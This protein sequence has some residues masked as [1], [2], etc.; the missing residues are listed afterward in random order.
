[1]YA[2]GRSPLSIGAAPTPRSGR[3]FITAKHLVMPINN[4][5]AR[6][7]KEKICFSPEYFFAAARPWARRVVPGW[8]AARGRRLVFP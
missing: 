4:I 5:A 7:C 1:P 2:K 6:Q 8:P 3:E